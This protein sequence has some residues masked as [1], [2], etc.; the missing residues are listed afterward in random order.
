MTGCLIIFFPAGGYT[1]SKST[2]SGGVEG[3]CG[4]G[5]WAKEWTA[6]MRSPPHREGGEGFVGGGGKSET[7][8]YG[9]TY[10]NYVYTNETILKKGT[11]PT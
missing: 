1:S 3:V 5:G 11:N 8:L 10:E 7:S 4:G 2:E 9:A 6:A